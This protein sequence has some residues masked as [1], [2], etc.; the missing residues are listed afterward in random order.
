MSH[1]MKLEGPFAIEEAGGR[2]ALC[3][4]LRVEAPVVFLPGLRLRVEGAGEVAADSRDTHYLGWLPRG[5][6]RVRAFLP[7]SLGAGAHRFSLEAVHREAMADTAAAKL[8]GAFTLAGPAA[9]PAD[10]LAWSFETVAPGVAIENLSWKRGHEDWFF[11]HFDHAAATVVSYMLADSP[12]LRG[13]IL[14]VG[15]GDGITALGVALRTGC[16][17]LVAIDP[18][19]GF[20]RLPEILRANHLPADAIPKRVKYLGE[21]ANFLPFADDSFD[22]VISWAAV[23]HFAGGYLQALREMKRVLRPGGLLFIHPGL[24][25]CNAG[26]HLAE[27]STEP[28]F[29]LRKSRDE[30]RAIVF[31]AKPRYE[32]RAGETPTPAQHWQWFNELNPIT[33]TRFEQELRALEFEPWRVAIRTEG[34]VEYTPETLAYPMQDLATNELYVSCVNRKRPKP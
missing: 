25:Y 3:G 1:A 10:G 12:K 30:I 2:A 13:R 11:R 26:H 32:D 17:E 27:Y 20:D 31:G 18:F 9:A 21:D 5:S 14:D 15:C 22:V 16:E 6:Y 4:R 28:F 33:V 19:R 8:E 29:H 24:Y 7:G 23:E 34:L